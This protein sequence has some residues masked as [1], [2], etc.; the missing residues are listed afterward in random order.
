MTPVSLIEIEL[1]GET[2]A[3][4]GD[5]NCIILK[6]KEEKANP[7]Y[8]TIMHPPL[9]SDMLFCQRLFLFAFCENLIK[10]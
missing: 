2:K 4:D 9:S 7:Y 10:N 6:E 5:L 8:I 3:P 1:Y